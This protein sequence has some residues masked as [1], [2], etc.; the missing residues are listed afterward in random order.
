MRSIGPLANP[1]LIPSATAEVLSSARSWEG[2]CSGSQ[3]EA[4]QFAGHSGNTRTSGYRTSHAAFLCVRSLSR[5]RR[6]ASVVKN[7][8]YSSTANLSSS[9]L[10]FAS[11]SAFFLH[12]LSSMCE[13]PVAC[14]FFLAA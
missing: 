8:S 9:A 11:A 5:R 7:R 2:A 4:D 12:S 6:D 1:L 10:I 13:R 14:N 3:P